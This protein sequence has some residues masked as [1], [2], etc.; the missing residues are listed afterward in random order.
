MTQDEGLQA[1]GLILTAPLVVARWTSLQFDNFAVATQAFGLGS[2]LLHNVV[3]SEGVL[4][5]G[6]P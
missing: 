3:G 1:L 5:T 2:T 6:L 4:C